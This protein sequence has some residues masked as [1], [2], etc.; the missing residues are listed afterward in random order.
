[1]I[2]NKIIGLIT[3]VIVTITVTET[4]AR[5]RYKHEPKKDDETTF[6]FA[7]GFRSGQN[8]IM[9]SLGKLIEPGAIV[10]IMEECEPYIKRAKEH[11][12]PR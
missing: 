7:C 3:A 5:Y 12:F 8:A 2:V 9:E 10:P 4:I 1:M 6:I 11:G